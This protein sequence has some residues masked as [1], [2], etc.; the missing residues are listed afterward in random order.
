MELPVNRF[1][2]RLLAGE[3][4][5]GLWCSFSGGYAAEMVAGAGFDWLMFDTEHSPGGVETTLTQLQAVAPYPVSPVVR[6]ASNDT[7]LIKKYLDIG[8]QTLLVPY[9]QSVEEAQAAVAAVRYPPEGVRGVAGTT[10]ASG[11]G[12]VKDYH[13]RAAAELCLL[14]QVE[15][16]QSL[17]RLE[18]IASVPGVDGVFIGPND[19]AASLGHPGDAGHPEV[20]AAVEGAMR[21]LKAIGKP[22]GIYTSPDFARRCIALGTT[23]AAVGGDVGILVKGA[24]ALAASFKG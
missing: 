4:Q 14:V 16:G 2:R 6:P 23:F 15:T 3:V 21:R 11:F 8:A 17:D 13:H 10:R 24:D 20:V 7:V 5:I 9:V 19:L 12:R 22:S 1:K 18:A